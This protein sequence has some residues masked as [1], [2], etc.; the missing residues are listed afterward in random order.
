MPKKEEQTSAAG[1]LNLRYIFGMKLRN[2]RKE[3]GLGLKELAAVSGLSAS[4]INEIEKGK[5]YPKAEKIML[6]AEGLGVEY[7]DLVSISLTGRLSEVSELLFSSSVL[8]SFPFQLF[9]ITF[10]N[11]MELFT[12]SPKK[13]VAFITTIMEISRSY[14]MHVEQFFLASLRAYQEMH[15]NYFEDVEEIAD[16][17]VSRQQ[18]KH[19]P[20]PGVEELT[21]TLLESHGV[22]ARAAD[23]SKYE[24]LKKQRFI[25]LPGNPSQLLLNDQLAPSQHVYSMALQIGYLELKLGNHVRTSPWKKF[26]SFD[27]VMGNF[28]ASYFAG[29]LMINRFRA[30]EEVK[31]I[32]QSETWNS[33]AILKFLKRHEV[34]PETFL[35][36]LSQILPGLFKITELHY[37]RFERSAGDNE[38]LLTKE[39]NM[40]R[41]LVPSGVRLKEHHC[42]RWLPV[43]LIED[44]ES[45]QKN[46]KTENILIGVQRAQFMGSGKEVLF[47]SI[48]HSLRLRTNINRCVSL[49]L[50]IDKSLKEKVKFLDDPQIPVKQVNQTCERCQLDKS[51]CSERAAP[52]NIYKSEE[53]EDGLNQALEQLTSDFRENKMKI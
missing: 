36:R 40:P 13:A 9:G 20:P 22:E 34:T 38:I 19:Y 50:S 2:Y 45:G 49:G 7:N 26:D 48:A 32:F 51:Q 12:A 11:V 52:P 24:E 39:L 31:E 4:Y 35:H 30:E 28:R 46:G 37:L 10:E 1:K 14:D 18:W 23:L 27:Q 16:Q 6:L 41:T 15:N 53:K 25:F 5:K 44:L 3:K 42:R 29:A 43:S 17:F 21:A 47:I 33:D 8:G